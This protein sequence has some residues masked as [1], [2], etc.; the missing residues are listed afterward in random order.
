MASNHPSQMPAM[1]T[2]TCRSDQPAKN[3]AAAGSLHRF[4]AAW[5]GARLRPGG[6]PRVVRFEIRPRALKRTAAALSIPNLETGRPNATTAGLK[7]ARSPWGGKPVS[8]RE[9]F[10]HDNPTAK[11]SSQ[12][13]PAPAGPWSTSDRT[14]HMRQTSLPVSLTVGCSTSNQPIRPHEQPEAT[15]SNQRP[16]SNQPQRPS[17][18]SSPSFATASPP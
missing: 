11:I 18:P 10:G 8:F 1:M 3:P 17:K 12:K 16:T 15:R 13:N 7:G 14:Y 5:A 6:R 9:L 4:P 2:T